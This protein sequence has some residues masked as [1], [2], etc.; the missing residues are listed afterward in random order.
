MKDEA[1]TKKQLIEELKDA[2][3]WETVAA[4]T[5][6]ENEALREQINELESRQ[7]T[8]IGVCYDE[9]MGYYLL[10]GSDE[11]WFECQNNEG[12]NAHRFFLGDGERVRLMTA[13]SCA[14]RETVVIE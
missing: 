9:E 3:A 6:A 12:A 4:D 11:Q 14:P 2:R 13:L 1:K 7:I 5:D 8:E 10:A